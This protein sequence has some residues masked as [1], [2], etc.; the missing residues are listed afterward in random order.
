MYNMTRIS[1]AVA[2]YTST[3]VVALAL[4]SSDKSPA[5]HPAPAAVE[6]QPAL[7]VNNQTPGIIITLDSLTGK[8]QSL[9]GAETVRAL[10][11]TL[12]DGLNFSSE[13]LIVENTPSG[14]KMVRLQGRFQSFAVAVT[15]TTGQVEIQCLAEEVSSNDS[16]G[17]PAAPD[18]ET[19]KR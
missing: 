15:N 19:S 10:S 18:T 8:I 16:T 11:Q 14:G 17:E 5:S 2:L 12:S 3:L 4:C 7:G 9:P 6:N 13:G 1:R